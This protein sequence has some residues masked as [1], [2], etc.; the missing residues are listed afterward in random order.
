MQFITAKKS[1]DI[2]LAGIKAELDIT[3]KSVNG[4]TFTDAEGNVVRVS[5]RSYSMAVEVPAPPVM[6]KR[7][8]VAGKLMGLTVN[9]MFDDAFNA[10]VR[11]EELTRLSTNADLGVQEVEIPEEQACQADADDLPF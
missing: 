5:L 9:E 10:E 4:V 3:D 2:K 1:S 6:V 11:V 8:K 7:Y